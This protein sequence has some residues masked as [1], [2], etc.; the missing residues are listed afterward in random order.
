M[1]KKYSKEKEVRAVRERRCSLCAQPRPALHLLRLPTHN[2]HAK[3]LHPQLE[4][5]HYRTANN[6]IY[7]TG[8][9]T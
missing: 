6:F 1:R 7:G 9:P 8:A 5:Y 2:L 3:Y 4:T